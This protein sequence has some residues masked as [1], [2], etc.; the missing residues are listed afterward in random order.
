MLIFTRLEATA[1]ETSAPDAPDFFTAA[2]Q[3]PGLK[4][5]PKKEQV[6][7]LVVDRA[8]RLPAEN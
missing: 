2:Q 1:S 6:E 3:Q 7:V 8:D 5:E 4:L